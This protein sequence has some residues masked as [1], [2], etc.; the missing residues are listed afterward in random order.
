MLS[1]RHLVEHTGAKRGLRLSNIHRTRHAQTTFSHLVGHAKHALAGL[2]MPALPALVLLLQFLYCLTHL[3][4]LLLE[5]SKHL[6][7]PG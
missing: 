7:R 4:H 2:V 3:V 1:P 5:R 6:V